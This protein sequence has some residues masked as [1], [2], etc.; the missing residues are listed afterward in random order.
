MRGLVV[1][2]GRC[3]EGTDASPPFQIGK[4]LAENVGASWSDDELA[5]NPVFRELRFLS[6]SKGLLARTGELKSQPTALGRAFSLKLL[7]EDLT[8]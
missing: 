1:R 5:Q 2:G 4:K 8:G 3:P 6:L 7:I